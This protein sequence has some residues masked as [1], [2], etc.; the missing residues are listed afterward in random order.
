[1][2]KQKKKKGQVLLYGLMAGI[3]IAI[4]MSHIDKAKT[5]KEFGIIGESSFSLIDSSVEAEKVLF[6]I[7]QS[8]KYSAHQLIYN[9]AKNGGYIN[10]KCGEF[11]GYT[12]WFAIDS[13]NNVI[14]CYPVIEDIK[15]IFKL[16]FNEDLNEYLK[17][18]PISFVKVPT[19]NYE[20]IILREKLDIIGAAKSNLLIS[21]PPGRDLNRE[22]T[23][24][25]IYSIR[26]SFKVAIDYD[27]DEYNKIAEE[28]KL[29]VS[30]C[31]NE[32]DAK[33]CIISSINEDNY[34]DRWELSCDNPN[35]KFDN[36]FKFCRKSDKKAFAYES[37]D[38]K[39]ALR[40][41]IYKFALQ[42]GNK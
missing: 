24:Y 40:E 12:L 36:I 6:Y 10:S 35:E 5:E 26:P 18:Y 13:Q 28:A 29:L 22:S 8:A 34:K 31:E 15:Y 20:E 14:D 42:F 41:I 32:A 1:M 38:D 33:T 39:I 7:E 23:T 11:N 17:K 3:L 21:I 9:L 19:D 16:D 25:G 2:I 30:K 4:T 37:K 27:F